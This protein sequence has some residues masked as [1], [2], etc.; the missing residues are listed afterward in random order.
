MLRCLLLVTG[1]ILGLISLLPSAQGQ[2]RPDATA[3]TEAPKVG[4][5]AIGRTP[6]ADHGLPD[7]GLT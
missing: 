1:A 2:G 3:T 7:G 4:V 5:L 6:L